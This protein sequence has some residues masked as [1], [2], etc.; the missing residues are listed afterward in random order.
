MSDQPDPPPPQQPETVNFKQLATST[1]EG[2]KDESL[3]ALEA[4]L[5]ELK[6]RLGAE[7]FIWTFVLVLVVDLFVFPRVSTWATPVVI[8]VLELL[9]L[10]VI[11]RL[12]GME[13]VSLF[14]DKMLS[15]AD[16]LGP[17]PSNKDK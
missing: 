7:R 8:G 16:K 14:V 13:D 11:A 1:E 4:D 5:S 9:F 10:I 6:D 12:T 15:M 17:K 3:V 2:A